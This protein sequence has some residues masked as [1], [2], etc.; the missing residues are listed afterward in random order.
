MPPFLGF[1]LVT[2]N[3]PAQISYLC[4]KLSALFDHPPIAI[5]NDYS[6]CALDPA[7]LPSQTKI[8]K[9]WVK[10]R[11]GD[12]KVI[13]AYL[14]ALR[15]LHTRDGPEWTISLSAADYPIKAAA[16]ILSDLQNASADAFLDFREISEGCIQPADTRSIASAFHRPDYM[17]LAGQRY[18][19]FSVIPRVLLKRIGNTNRTRYLSGELLTRFFTPFSNTY[20]P[21][22]GDWWHTI[23]RRA[24]AVLIEDTPRS[25]HLRR[26]YNH[27]PSPEES[28]YHTLL[29]NRPDLTIENDNRRF[30][31][32]RQGQPHPEVLGYGD[33][34]NLV[35]SPAHFARKFTFDPALYSALDAAVNAAASASLSRTG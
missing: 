7:T 30:T 17:H 5:H 29:L 11:W 27:R 1:A 35:H 15:L 25:R 33:I 9:D 3:Q 23:N 34:E 24:A 12:A 32:W 2:H 14:A 13:D 6:K 16:R 21:F 31:I 20:L 28:Y 19:S 8:V 18:L 22:A 4:H 10:T 26:Y